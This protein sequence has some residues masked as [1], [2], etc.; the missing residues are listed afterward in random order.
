MRRPGFTIIELLV[1]LATGA[2]VST[3]LVSVLLTQLRLTRLVAARVSAADAIRL[4]LYVLP[5]ELRLASQATDFHGLG[6]DSVALRL[7]RASGAVCARAAG[8]LW[9]RASGMRE[10]DPAKDSLLL[11]YQS[12]ETAAPLNG[13]STGES[14]PCAPLAGLT[15]YRVDT[16]AD[17]GAAAVVIFESGT[18]YLRDRALRFRLGDEGRQPLTEE[19]FLNAPNPFA[20]RVDSPYVSFAITL[21]P[22]PTFGRALASP[23]SAS[24]G[25]PNALRGP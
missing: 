12:G 1:A 6:A 2:M 9:I 5:T 21:V 13:L 4:A 7:P 25:L 15:I 11:V 20:L 19:V 22:R 18:Y 24:F 3:A 17:S 16:P 10:P 8:R 14:G 23:A